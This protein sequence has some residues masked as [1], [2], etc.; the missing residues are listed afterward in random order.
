MGS[1]QPFCIGPGPVAAATNND[2]GGADDT[3]GAQTGTA[4]EHRC[5]AEDEPYD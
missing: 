4:Q 2:E 5:I 1:G 3:A